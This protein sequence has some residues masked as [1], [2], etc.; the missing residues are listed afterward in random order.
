MNMIRQ[1]TGIE[2]ERIIA[3]APMVQIAWFDG[4]A[5]TGGTSFAGFA[6]I[7]TEF[8]FRLQAVAQVVLVDVEVWDATAARY[9]V[10]GS[11]ELVLFR[12]SHKVAHHIGTATLAELL[13]WAGPYLTHSGCVVDV[14]ESW[15]M[16]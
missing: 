5:E 9:G 8:A 3:T 10:F 2:L 11:P 6:K 7:M 4:T 13:L 1:I 14:R 12:N 16:E 15:R